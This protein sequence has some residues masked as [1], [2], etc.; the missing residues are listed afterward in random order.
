M[1]LQAVNH[2][3]H[4]IL[5]PSEADDGVLG[6]AE[7]LYSWR[8]PALLV[9]ELGISNQ[10]APRGRRGWH[11]EKEYIAKARNHSRVA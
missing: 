4:E 1:R 8:R 7:P 5:V 10:W 2:G 9:K 6:S 3:S 11:V